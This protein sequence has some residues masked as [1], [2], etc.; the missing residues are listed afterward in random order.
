MFRQNDT[1]L[2]TLLNMKICRYRYVGKT[3]ISGQRHYM[4]SKQLR[5]DD[6]AILKNPK[7]KFNSF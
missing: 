2:V 7:Y 6:F 1:S 4:M 5:F 3:K